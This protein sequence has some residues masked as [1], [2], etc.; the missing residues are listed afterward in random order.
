VKG[1]APAPSVGEFKPPNKRGRKSKTETETVPVPVAPPLVQMAE[2]NPE[3]LI[4]TVRTAD[5]Y[6]NNNR[7]WLFII[8]CTP[9]A[10]TSSR[11][12]GSVARGVASQL[13]QVHYG[14]QTSGLHQTRQRED[15][16]KGRQHTK[17]SIFLSRSSA[18]HWR[19]RIN[20]VMFKVVEPLLH[21]KHDIASRKT[22]DPFHFFSIW[23][24]TSQREQH[25]Y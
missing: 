3:E 10:Q 13:R 19:R 17:V 16:L 4:S 14:N 2:F 21:Q 5:L 20:R 24:V 7:Y 6:L 1:G 25:R 9:L 8:S 23:W 11:R 15:R 12:D 22:W 18:F